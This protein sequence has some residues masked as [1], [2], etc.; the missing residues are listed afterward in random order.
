VRFFK[1]CISV[2]A[3]LAIEQYFLLSKIS[4]KTGGDA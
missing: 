1:F 2:G 3:K 4:S